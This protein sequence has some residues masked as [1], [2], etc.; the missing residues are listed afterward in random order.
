MKLEAGVREYR[1]NCELQVG[2]AV[3]DAFHKDQKGCLA[4]LQNC[5]EVE[6][7]TKKHQE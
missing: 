3:G 5:F 4:R 6:V 7:C 1:F 2:G